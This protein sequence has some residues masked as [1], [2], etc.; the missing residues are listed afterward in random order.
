MIQ[1]WLIEKEHLRGYESTRGECKG[2]QGDDY[3]PSYL[4]LITFAYRNFYVNILFA[5]FVLMLMLNRLESLVFGVTKIWKWKRE[6]WKDSI[7]YW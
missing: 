2:I 7:H 3:K 1:V 5:H 4:C 6:K